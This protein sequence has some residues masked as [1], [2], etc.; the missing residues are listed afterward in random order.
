MRF[1]TQKL[2]IFL[3]LTR[4]LILILPWLTITLLFPEIHA[5]NF[6]EFTQTSW[7]RWDALHYLYLATHWYQNT[8][9]EANFIV[10]FPLY[11]LL[12]KAVIYFFSSPVFSAIATSTVFF[13][14]GAYF[15]YKLVAIDYPEKVARMATVALAIF[16]TSFFFNAP[17]TES[18]FLFTFSA[19]LYSARKGKW[20]LAGIFTGLGCITRPFGILVLPAVIIE[21]FL[22]KNHKWRY[23]LLI[24][25]PSVVAVLAYLYLN[26]IV[27]NDPFTFQKTLEVHWQKHLMSPLA[28]IIDA[29][30]I[31]FSGGLNNYTVIVGWAEAVSI[32][33]S[34]ILIPFAFLKL[35]KSWAVF[36]FLSIVLFSST[37][38]ILSTPRYLLS[39]PPFFVLIAIAEKNYLFRITWRFLSIALLF[40]LAIL[41][42]RGQWAF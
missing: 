20:L 3:F 15:F 16:P 4:L 34:W 14:L 26:K 1:K 40:C 12:L 23:I 10:F 6:F 37:S 13:M 27:Y 36:Y 21:W 2:L 18:L 30:R 31:A 5:L 29:W 28:G 8:G 7:D 42:T 39:I 24:V 11:P 32:T 25:L 19:S 17:Y 33:L 9:D 22:G 35:R 41:F 38:F